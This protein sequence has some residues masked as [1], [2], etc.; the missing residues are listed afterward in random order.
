MRK[1]DVERLHAPYSETDPLP[2]RFA[3]A[4]GAAAPSVRRLHDAVLGD[5]DEEARGVDWWQA[6][7]PPSS[8]T[9]ARSIFAHRRSRVMVTPPT[10][11]ARDW[12]SRTAVTW[13]AS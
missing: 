10:T 1:G 5:F 7:H 8:L 2:E 11:P 13:P 3:G 12:P 4:I 9:S 6:T